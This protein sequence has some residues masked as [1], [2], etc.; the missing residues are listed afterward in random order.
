MRRGDICWAST[1]DP[2][3]CG[4]GFRRPVVVLQSDD[5]NQSTLRTTICA[6]VTSNVR[7]AEAPGNVRLTR[8]A[9]GLTKDSV[10]NVSQLLTLDKQRLSERVGRVSAE[11]LHAVEAGVR[12]VLAL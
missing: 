2:Q 9:S 1:D 8:K 11:T 6:I 7:L 4:P 10:V 3:G 5:F 12:L